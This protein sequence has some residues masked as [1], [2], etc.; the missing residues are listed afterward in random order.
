LSDKIDFKA[1]TVAKNKEG[2]YLMK[3]ATNQQ[4]DVT[5]ADIYAP[6]M[7]APNP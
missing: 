4:E 1:K 6:K 3:K 2:H 7:G 5:T